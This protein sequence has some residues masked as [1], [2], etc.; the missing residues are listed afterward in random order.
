MIPGEVAKAMLD[1]H[2][3]HGAAVRSVLEEGYRGHASELA[4]RTLPESCILRLVAGPE[5]VVRPVE[6]PIEPPPDSPT[7][8]RDF[9]RTSAIR[10]AI[11]DERQRVI[12]EGMPPLRGDSTFRVLKVL[13]AAAKRDRDAGL[14]PEHH[15]YLLAR[16]LASETGLAEPSLRHSIYRIR[17]QLALEIEARAGIPL[18]EGALIE[19]VRWRGY[20]LN[21]AVLILAAEEIAPTA[22]GHDSDRQTSQLPEDTSDRTTG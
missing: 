11:D 6:G 22:I 7:D 3:R 19:N 18:S 9:K 14:A 17:R 8:R 16:K 10:L 15:T 12:V 1:L 21:P 13:A 4:G 20:R 5:G 2:R